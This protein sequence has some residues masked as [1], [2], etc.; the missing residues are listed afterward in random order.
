[1]ICTSLL[2]LYV[3]FVGHKVPPRVTSTVKTN[4]ELLDALQVTN[5]ELFAL[6]NN[7]PRQTVPVQAKPDETVLPQIQRTVQTVPLFQSQKPVPAPPGRVNESVEPT[8][9]KPVETK[10]WQPPP[11]PKAVQESVVPQYQ[12]PVQMKQWNAPRPVRQVAEIIL[13]EEHTSDAEMPM[14]RLPEKSTKS[15]KVQIIRIVGHA[16]LLLLPLIGRCDN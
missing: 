8:S 3:H 4:R 6:A 7:L 16:S 13:P 9:Q 2:H 11:P 15:I 12:K 14:D 5:D 1:M 10:P